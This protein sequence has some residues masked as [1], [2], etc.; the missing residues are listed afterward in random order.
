MSEEEDFQDSGS[1]VEIE[2]E[3]EPVEVKPKVKAEKKPKTPKEPKQVKEKA[4]RLTKAG[5]PDKR[6]VT[7]SQN[8]KKAQIIAKQLIAKAKAVEYESS[9]EDEYEV[10]RRKQPTQEKSQKSNNDF[11]NY[12]RRLKELEEENKKLKTSSNNN[13]DSLMNIAL[14]SSNIL[15]NPNRKILYQ[16]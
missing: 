2:L 1:E 14:Q 5:K 11:E 13:F 8:L 12:E 15:T 10:V 6:A 4:V 16:L 9:S 7:S 3:E